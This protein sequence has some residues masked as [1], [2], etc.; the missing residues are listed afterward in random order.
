[1]QKQRKIST[2]ALAYCA[3][4]T[5][6]SVVFARLIGL[7]PNESMRFSLEAVPIFLA[8]M[9]FGPLLGGCVGFAADFI[10]CLFSPFGYNPIF[11]IPPILY[12]V[13][14]GLLRPLFRKQVSILRLAVA[15]LLPVV[16]GS[17]LYQSAAL[18]YMYYKDGPFFQGFVYYLSTRSVQFSITWAADVLAVYLIFKA[19]LFERIGLWNSGKDEKQ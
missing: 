1:M 10:G 2:K 7:M 8:G 5:A 6:L 19:R 15:F 12:G 11:C 14:A 3:M 4:L 9:L 16:I 13:F 17:L 18:A